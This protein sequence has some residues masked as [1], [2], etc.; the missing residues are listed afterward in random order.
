MQVRISPSRILLDRETIPPKDP[1]DRYQIIQ[2]TRTKMID[3]PDDF[4]MLFV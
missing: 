4:Q 2:P 3:G 1:G